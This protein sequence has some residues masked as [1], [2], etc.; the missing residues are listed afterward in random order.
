MAALLL[1]AGGA[2]YWLGKR[3]IQVDFS[4]STLPR[5]E[6]TNTTPPDNRDVDFSLFWEVWKRLERDYID[7]SKINYQ[8]MVWGAIKGMTAAIGDPYTVFLPPEQNE[9]AAEDLN[10][11]FEGIG[12]QLGMKDDRIIV[13]APLKG[14][15]AERAGLRAGDW[16]ISVD[17]VETFGWTV[18]EAVEHIRGPKGE[19]VK[20]TVLHEGGDEPVDISILRDM[21]QVPS[22]EVSF[23]RNVAILRLYQFGDH[24]N[25]EWEKNINTIVGTCGDGTSKCE[26]VILDLRNNPGGYLHESVT[27]VSE[28]I[29]EGIVVI[30]ENASGV[31]EPFTVKKSGK[32]TK[33]PLVVLINKGSASASEI[34]AGSLRVH[35]RT[36]LVGEQSFGK[37]SIQE[38]QELPEGAGLHITTAKWL[39]PDETWINSTGLTPDVVIA[40]DPETVDIDEQLEKGIELLM[41]NN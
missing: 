16:I 25:L 6:V 40:D 24:T 1:L 35:N 18:P 8:N 19:S 34:V 20:I 39:L 32:L 14:M 29:S 36:Q 26:G 27:I 9:Q 31:K 33:I 3:D 5:V 37:G 10:G 23:E 11:R 2:G 15:P 7:K 13:I 30:Q 21:I 17:D 41:A 22:V 38:R 28:F 4:A 12:A